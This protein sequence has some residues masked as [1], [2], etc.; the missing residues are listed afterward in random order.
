MTQIN[1]DHKEQDL[2]SATTS[3]QAFAS[4]DKLLPVRMAMFTRAMQENACDLAFGTDAVAGEHGR[5]AEMPPSA[6]MAGTVHGGPVS[7]MSRAAEALGLQDRIGALSPGMD[8]DLIAV[9]GDPRQDVTAVRR[10]VFVMKGGKVY[11][12]LP[13]SRAK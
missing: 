9:D 3:K 5:N 10:V 4:M 2:G 12:S 11:K 1:L 8:A 7:A 6:P 13:R